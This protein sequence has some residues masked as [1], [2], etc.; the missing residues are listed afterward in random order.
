MD[1]SK[2]KCLS[3]EEYRNF[4]NAQKE[5]VQTVAELRNKLAKMQQRAEQAERVAYD[6]KN[7]NSHLWTLVKQAEARAGAA[8]MQPHLDKDIL[9]SR[10]KQAEAERDVL[11]SLVSDPS[12]PPDF[13]PG[14][15]PYIKEPDRPCANCWLTWTNQETAKRGEVIE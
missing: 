13:I 15:C 11:I 1:E 14:V 12:C 9:L 7:K 4:I 2:L 10:A 8:L 5:I 3:E 6:L